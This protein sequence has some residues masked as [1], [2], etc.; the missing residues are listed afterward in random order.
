MSQRE[1]GKA[2]RRQRIID[3][4]RAL[5]AEVGE[6]GFSM[7]TLA[8]RAGVSPATPYNLFG[9][10]HL[11]LLT[12][13]ND[14]LDRFLAEFEQV[15][16]VDALDRVFDFV[17]LSRLTYER[18][19]RFYRVVMQ[20]ISTHAPAD[21][22]SALMRPRSHVF[23]HLAAGVAE[24]GFLAPGIDAAVL[25]RMINFVMGGALQ[26]W[27]SQEITVDQYEQEVCCGVA[28]LLAGSCG[29]AHRERL[30]QRV[31]SHQQRLLADDR[32]AGD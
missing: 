1:A 13:L 22:R 20:L 5:I 6:G 27:I 23:Q 17:R 10:K 14:D 26:A 32:R 15:E 7:R 25:G 28:M 16:S 4:A 2:A 30:R 24:A 8:L 12:V 21:L 9:N 18:Q 19:P 11:V 3:A 31:L 29:D